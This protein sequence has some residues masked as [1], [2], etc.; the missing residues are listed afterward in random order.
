ME[1]NL[2]RALEASSPTHVI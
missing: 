1:N 2:S